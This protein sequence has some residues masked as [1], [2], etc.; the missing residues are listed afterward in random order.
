[1]KADG[2]ERDRLLAIGAEAFGHD[3]Q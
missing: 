1:V 3:D 2:E